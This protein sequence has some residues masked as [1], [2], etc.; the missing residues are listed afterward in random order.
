MLWYPNTVRRECPT[1]NRHICPQ[2]THG[3]Q[4]EAQLTSA[5]VATLE[6]TTFHVSPVTCS[7]TSSAETTRGRAGCDRHTKPP[8]QLCEQ[9]LNRAQ[10]T[11]SGRCSL[12]S[13]LSHILQLLSVTY[14][15]HTRIYCILSIILLHCPVIANNLLSAHTAS[16]TPSLFYLKGLLTPPPCVIT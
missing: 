4:S 10:I 5:N 16:S 7:D 8:S 11:K 6:W 3:L 15:F 9:N 13:D 1:P 2:E 14:S 12:C